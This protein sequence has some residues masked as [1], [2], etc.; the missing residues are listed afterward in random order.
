VFEFLH[1]ILKSFRIG[2][3]Q[4]QFGSASA[5]YHYPTCG[6]YTVE[7]ISKEGVVRGSLRGFKRGFKCLVVPT[8][9]T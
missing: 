2:W 1:T 3:L 8:R 5:C 7:Q 9:K 6:D 4:S